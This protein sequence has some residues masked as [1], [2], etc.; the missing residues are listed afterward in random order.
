MQQWRNPTPTVD[1]I[2]VR[3]RTVLLIARKNEPHGWAL[4]GGFVDEGERVGAAAVREVKEETGLD[5]DLESLFHVYSDPSR[6]PRKHTLS[7]VFIGA[8]EGEAQGSDDA[9]DA[10]WFDL[11]ALPSP[12][13]FDHGA[14]L[15]DFRRWLDTGLRPAPHV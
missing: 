7:V 8:A 10:A 4:P 1:V 12:L 6:D 3:G 15:A 13:A 2:L 11:D 9:A 5:A 14:I